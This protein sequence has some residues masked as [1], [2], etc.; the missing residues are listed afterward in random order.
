MAGAHHEH[1]HGNRKADSKHTH[2]QTPSRQHPDSAKFV[3]P[4]GVNTKTFEIR[5]LVV[6][7]NNQA[8]SSDAAVAAARQGRSQLRARASDSESEPPQD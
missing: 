8:V 3:L 6:S 1:D 7:R 4:G 5:R 2:Q